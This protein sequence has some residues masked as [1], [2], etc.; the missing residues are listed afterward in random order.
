[1]KYKLKICL[2]RC[3]EHSFFPLIILAAILFNCQAA[4]QT[5]N[6][7]L[8]EQTDITLMGV[9]DGSVKWGDYDNDGDLDILLTGYTGLNKVAPVYRNNGDGTFSEKTAVGLTGVDIGSVDWGDYDNDGDIDILL[10]GFSDSGYVTKIYR[11]EGN[12]SFAEQT[13]I[14]LPQVVYSAA[15]WGDY[16]NDGL[17]DILLT[18][19]TENWITKLYHN[20]GDNTFTDVFQAGLI[21]VHRSAV[22]WG[23]FD[24]DGDMDIVLTGYADGGNIISSVFINHNGSFSEETGIILSG[25]YDGSVDWGDLD[26][27]GRLDLVLTGSGIAEIYHNNGDRSFSRL[28]EINLTGVSDSSV[29][30]GDLDN[31]GDMDIIITGSETAKV[32]RNNGDNTFTEQTGA[33]LTGVSNSA[34]ALGDYDNDGDLDLL[35]TGET[36][37]GRI[38]KIYRNDSLV[39]NTSPAAPVG[40]NASVTGDSVELSWSRATDA[41]TPQDGLTYNIRIGTSEGDV[42]IMSPMSDLVTGQRMTV[43]RGNVDTNA[44]WTIHGLKP[45]TYYWSVQA[46]DAAYAGSAFSVISSFTINDN[47]YTDNDNDGMLDDWEINNNLDPNNNDAGLDKDG[48]RFT[49]GREYQDQTDPDDSSSHLVFPAITGRVPDTGQTTSYTDT[50][51]EDSDYLI[52]PPSY[53][54]MDAQGN[55]LPNSATSWVMVR[56]N[57]TGLIWESKTDDGSV[58]DKDNTYTWYDSNPETNGGDAGTPGDGT[59]TEDFINALNTSNYG[60]YSDWRMPTIKELSY[61]TKRGTYNPAINID[62][63]PYTVSSAYWSS[64]VVMYISNCAWRVNFIY[65]GIDSYYKSNSHY[66]RAVRGGQAG[67]SDSL[68]ING[69]G[70]VTDTSTGLMW[71]Q[72]TAAEMAWESAISYCEDLSLAGY[73]DWRLPNINEVRSLVDYSKY[74]NPAIDI[75]SFPDTVSS[76]YWSSTTFPN[77][78]NRAWL[79]VFVSGYIVENAKS[80][81]Y[82][83]RAVRGGQNRLLGHL[84]ISSPAQGSKWGAGSTMP[85]TWDTAGISGNVKISISRDGGK[86]YEVIIDSTENDGTY[87]WT[88]DGEA[89]VNCMLRIEP[90]TDPSKE[91]VQGLFSISNIQNINN[92]PNTPSSPSPSHQAS[93]VSDNADL[94]WVGGDSNI[95]DTVTY[96]VYWGTDSGSLSV[97]S[98]NQ[99]GTSYDPGVL[100]YSTTYYWKAVARD[101]QGAET[102]SPVWS[103]TTLAEPDTIAPT[104]PSNLIANPAPQTWSNDTTIEI[105]WTSGA[106]SESGVAGYSIVW[107]TTSDTLPDNTVETTQTSVAGPPRTDGNNHYFHIHTIDNAGNSSTTVHMGPFYID[108]TAPGSPTSPQSTSHTTG[109]CSSDRTINISWTAPDGGPSNISGYAVIWDIQTDTIPGQGINQTG[110]SA[111]SPSLSDGSNHWVHIR[112]ADGAGNWSANAL[113][114]GPFCIETSIPAPE[115]LIA[116]SEGGRTITLK[117]G[118]ILSNDIKG[119]NIYRSDTENGTYVRIN[120]SLIFDLIYEGGIFLQTYTDDELVNGITYWYRIK[121]VNQADVESTISAGISGVP[122]PISGGD[123][124]IDTMEDYLVVNA[125]DL[126]TFHITIVAEDR[127]DETVTLHATSMDLPSQVI[128]YFN[129]NE[130][131][132]TGSANLIIEAPYPAQVGEY[133]IKLNAYSESRSHEAYLTVKIVSLAGSDSLIT[134]F[135]EDDIIRLDQNMV[136]QGQLLP[137]QPVGTSISV[138]IKPPGTDTWDQ[139]PVEIG[140]NSSYYFTLMPSG[141]GEYQ[142]KAGWNG[143]S[144]YGACE[145]TPVS[146]TVGKGRSLIRCSTSTPNIEPG[147]KVDIRINLQPP[148][149]GVPFNLE[150]QKPNDAQAEV[151]NNLQIQTQGERIFGYTLPLDVPGIWKFKA[152]W[153]GNE[154]YL[155]AISIPLVLYPGVPVGEALIVAGGGIEEN[156]LWPSTEYL[157]NRFYK[158]LK[159]RR[160]NHDQIY[161]IS[162]HSYNYDLNGDGQD[163]IIVDDHNPSVT[164][165]QNYIEGL[166]PAE[167]QPKVDENKPLI[168]YIM[169]HG[170]DGKIKINSGVL[171][172][173]TDLDSWLDALQTATNCQVVIITEACHSGTFI[174]ALSPGEG[175]DRILISSSNTEVSNYDQGGIQSFSQYFLNY[176]MQGND[177]Y[178]SFYKTKDTL[179]NRYLFINQ[180]PQIN[181]GSGGM[182]ASNFYI[183][184]TFLTADI[185][186]EI[187]SYTPNQVINAGIFDLF[188]DVLDV[189][190][191]DSAWVSIM[192]PDFIPPKTTDEFETPVIDLEK[193]DLLDPEE[194]STYEGSFDFKYNGSYILTFFARDTGGNVVTQEVRLIVENGQES[195]ITGDMNDDQ[196]VDIGDAILVLRALENIEMNEES[197]NL[198]ADVNG[199]GMIGLEE[200]IYVLRK[201]AGE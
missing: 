15:A 26:S 129:H 115:N 52:N 77:Y 88:V 96:D 39:Q 98:S 191:L 19:Q 51:G 90:I 38:A 48:D 91:T 168:I 60:G 157:A 95:G 50:F 101:N 177:L 30:L 174:S 3:I 79:V 76:S 146:V 93:Y 143:N 62:Y 163:D 137:W 160:F 158:V 179:S 100:N 85:I 11:N 184:G 159:D 106:D 86:T 130:I 55:Y 124:R 161:Y 173:A 188:V 59:D 178:K 103:F 102:S 189:E 87:T 73:S 175:Q 105:S 192:P 37:Y 64:T 180:N 72:E 18:G 84:I 118:N 32:Y 82:Y 201:V 74:Y 164:D 156:T 57:V 133:T 71:Q 14:E 7:S 114:F 34:T 186:P 31:D 181:D 63:F 33:G 54:K 149:E 27:D 125:G 183:G 116:Q 97:V 117:W 2:K 36:P 23:D 109:Q 10:T 108:I 123:F 138:F 9:L 126:A 155:G 5:T 40:L 142:V 144:Y 25:V 70:T 46:I 92:P 56:D 53:I 43:D 139:Y 45:G 83:L 104:P 94:S 21:G 107:D 121:A 24:N 134:A 44:G 131:Q 152:V 199:D 12:G 198:K 141:L 150:I 13:G 162:P 200:A 176:V 4:A 132:P 145:S 172:A 187:I 195:L 41:E 58:H 197:L 49:N 127:F 113:H 22:D 154:D 196:K 67:L 28:T 122:Q 153:Q 29:A 119:Y 167:L 148:L 8:V 75:S 81:S 190:G 1:M 66:V 69:D 136:I 61:I 99:S 80:S 17:L 6:F 20:N 68:A 140:E 151:I 16:D 193:V 65:G 47:I 78:S 165:I 147:S 111:V 35:L 170:G 110:T 171:L 185:M 120:S 112:A 42:D 128:K 166:Y 182:L 89:S 194:D 169:D 135:P